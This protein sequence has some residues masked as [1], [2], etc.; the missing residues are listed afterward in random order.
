MAV[1]DH[2]APKEQTIDPI[3][4]CRKVK[5]LFLILTYGIKNVRKFSY[6][7]KPLNSGHIWVL[8]KLS[9]IERCPLLGGNLKKVVTFGT[10][11]FVRYSW[12]AR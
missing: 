5:K 3:C 11:L 8:K 9:V 2:Q 4:I 12:H 1:F 6:T 10:K 7:V